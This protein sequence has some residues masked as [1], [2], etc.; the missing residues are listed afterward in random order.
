M[1]H[2]LL[3]RDVRMIDEPMRAQARSMLSGCALAVIA[4]AGCAIVA[5]VRPEDALG[6]A[7]IMM[8]KESGAL[9]VRV[10]DTLHPVLNLASARLIAGTAAKPR[11]IGESELRKANRG[12]ALGIP[13]APAV[14]PAPLP[15]DESPWTVCDDRKGTTVIVGALA[16]GA[17]AQPLDGERTMLVRSR[18]DAAPYLLYAGRRARVSLAEPAVVKALRLDGIEPL[19]V[20]SSVLDAIPEAPPITAPL[21]PAAGQRGPVTLGGMPVG[22]VVRVDRADADELYV[23]LAEGA[24]RVGQVAADVVRFSDSQGSRDIVTVA[25]DAIGATPPAEK[26]PL[27]TFPDAAAAPARDNVVCAQWLADNSGEGRSRVLVASAVPLVAGQAPVVLAQADGIGPNADAV[28][29][30][31]GR[32]VYVESTHRYLVADTGVRFGVRDAETAGALG[33]PQLAV[34]APWPILK[35]LADGPELSR[36]AALVAHDGLAADPGAVA[37]PGAGTAPAPG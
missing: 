2:A 5:F 36:A 7:P 23:V 9:Y 16:N 14:L 15:P 18:S 11:V 8:V 26:L 35:L 28:L 20:S 17:A 3:R 25:A 27:S 12:A 34:P 24:Q 19:E 32:C 22:T 21:I 10:G 29:I 4:M 31:P 6:D 33:L 30:P 13:G 37:L 1:E